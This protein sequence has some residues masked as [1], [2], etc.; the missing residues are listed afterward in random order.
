MRMMKRIVF[1]TVLIMAVLFV[2][3][4]SASLIHLPDS[5]YGEENGWQGNRIY[6]EN[7]FNVLVEFNV[8]D[9]ELYPDEFSWVGDVE[10]PDADRYIYAYQIFNHPYADEDVA[11]FS[12][13]DIAG[14][15]VEQDLIHST[16]SQDDGNG[17]VTPLES[18]T[19]GAWEFDW[20]T[21]VANAHSYFLIF[22]SVHAPVA[23]NFE[24][25][26]YE[27]DGETPV[28]SPSPEPGM[29]ALFGLGS[30]MIFRRRRK[31]AQ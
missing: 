12:V 2:Q 22:S 3:S 31:S 28:P 5:T 23:G 26:A 16:C 8:Y 10:M 25:R 7:G 11:Y 17:G 24:V 4:A 30:A 6:N 19:Q 1:L 18:D 29:L 20:G 27:E 21:L 15:A 14:E 13:L 9:T